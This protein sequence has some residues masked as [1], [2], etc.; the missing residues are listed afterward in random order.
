MVCTLRF[1]QCAATQQL[2][3]RSLSTARMYKTFSYGQKSSR[4][5]CALAV[6]SFLILVKPS[7][8]SNQVVTNVAS[9]RVTVIILQNRTERKLRNSVGSVALLSGTEQLF[10]INLYSNCSCGVIYAVTELHIYSLHHSYLHADFNSECFTDKLYS[11]YIAGLNYIGTQLAKFI[12]KLL[13]YTIVTHCVIELY[14]LLLY[15][16]YS[17]IHILYSQILYY[18]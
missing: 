4:D 17:Y 7:Q 9:E 10:N 3:E 6:H 8:T 14:L 18:R 1:L 11:N 12:L 16:I 13:V 15:Y 2:L 5:M